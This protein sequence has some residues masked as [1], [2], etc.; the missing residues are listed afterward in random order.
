MQ[1]LI[2]DNE[3]EIRL[4]LRQMLHKYCPQV[5]IIYEAQGMVDGLQLIQNEVLDVLFLDVELDDGTGIELLQNLNEIPFQVVFITAHNHYA[6]EA[7][8]FSA[9]DFLLKP[10]DIE[11]LIRSI[12]RV[13]TNL[14][15]QKII[16]QVKVM[17]EDTS[18][19]Q[20]KKKIVLRDAENLHF[21]RVSDILYCEADGVYTSFFL[22]NGQTILVSKNLKEYESML[23]VFRFLRVHHSFL[24]NLEKVERF[25]KS[26]GGY[27][28]LSNQSKI[29]VSHRKKEQVLTELAKF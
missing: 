2:I 11:E 17:Q 16:E 13:Q 4:G 20:A 15:K 5:S 26:E 7:F 21:V 29:P 25:D 8:K 24:V 9:I 10:I 19:W 28:V 18:T 3:P 27:L 6:V 23:Q 22:E 1:V 14:D 12:R